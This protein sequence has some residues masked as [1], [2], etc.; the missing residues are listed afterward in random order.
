MKKYILSFAILAFCF[1]W[2]CRSKEVE[3]QQTLPNAAPP[4]T[5][6]SPFVGSSI[7]PGL[8]IEGV[9]DIVINDSLGTIQITLPES[10]IPMINMNFKK[11]PNYTF[12]F[13]DYYQPIYD[14]KFTFDELNE[15]G[16]W[17]FYFRGAPPLK[18]EL[19]NKTTKVV[20]SYLIYVTQINKKLDAQLTALK[21]SSAPYI[22]DGSVTV[23]ISSMPGTIPNKPNVKLPYVILKKS[24]TMVADTSF[25]GYSSPYG[26]RNDRLTGIF[27][28]DNIVPSEGQLFDMELVLN[29][30]KQYLITNFKILKTKT[31]VNIGG[32]IKMD[33]SFGMSGGVF[34]P[35]NTYTLQFT[36]DY[37]SNAIQLNATVKNANSL[38]VESP[39]SIPLGGYLVDV[40]ENGIFLQRGV[41]NFGKEESAVAIGRFSKPYVEYPSYI[42]TGPSSEKTILEKDEEFL[43]LPVNYTSKAYGGSFSS[44]D[45][46]NIIAPI[47]Q[48]TKSSNVINL[49]PIKKVITMPVAVFHVLHFQYTIPKSTES[50]F[51]EAQLIYPDGRESLKYWNKIEIK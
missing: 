4:V 30:E 22:F 41:M 31:R 3:F 8:S 50:G 20:K 29:D 24:G 47:L 19:Q 38:I 14:R 33:K 44:Q 39:K 2:S 6:E 46:E 5:I 9:S 11:S 42:F 1:V 15:W 40:F 18:I 10:Y 27:K 7:L 32:I 37:I 25:L 45:L 36:N 28:L 16:A 21:F 12:S 17:G 51:Y 23:D 13:Y 43:L 34:L 48:L 35:S 26:D 49:T